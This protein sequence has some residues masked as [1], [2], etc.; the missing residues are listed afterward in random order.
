[1][2]IKRLFAIGLLAIAMALTACSSTVEEPELLPPT[3]PPVPEETPEP[4]PEP[5][6]RNPLTGERVDEDISHMRPWAI[7]INNLRAALPQHGLARADIIYEMLVE[8]GI[9]RLLAVFQDIEGV[10]E[11]GPIR[12][13]RHYFLDVAQGHDAIFVHAGGSPQ[14]YAAIRDRGVPNIDGVQGS[15]REFFRDQGRIQTAGFEHSMLTTDQLLL[16]NVDAHGYRRVH[17]PSFSTGLLFRADGT[18]EGGID[19]QE[20]TVQFSSQKTGVFMFD[21]VAGAYRVSQHGAPHIDG[22][23][24][25]QLSMTNVLVLVADFAVIDNEGRMGVDLNLGGTGYFINGGRAV[26]ILW[27]KGGYAAPFRFTLVNGEPLE[28]GV[29]PS[30]INVIDSGSSSVTFQ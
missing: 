20:V 3:P 17:D 10:G 7:Q 29:G 6:Y 2:S 28:L 25:S 19:A 12:S 26:P 15:G 24:G 22:V 1:M 13:A 8:G 18:P 14:A 11:I 5:G 27:T 4:T 23:T 9:T 16:D 21:P 30:Y